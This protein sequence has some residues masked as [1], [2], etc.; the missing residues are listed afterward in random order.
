MAVLS[1]QF[2]GAALL[3]FPSAG[4]AAA[5]AVTASAGAAVRRHSATAAAAVAAVATASS[6]P[7]PTLYRCHR[8]GLTWRERAHHLTRAHLAVAATLCWQVAPSPTALSST[9]TAGA[10]CV[11]LRQL[12]RWARG[13]SQR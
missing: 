4:A 13:S 7:V 10:R 3:L 8:H 9:S 6:L 1:A 12:C 11:P 2:V 5:A